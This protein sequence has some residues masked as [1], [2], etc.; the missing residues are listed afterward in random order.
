MFATKTRL[1]GVLSAA[2]LSLGLVACGGDGDGGSGVDSDKQLNELTDAEQI[3]LCESFSAEG[4]SISD[5]TIKIICHLFSAEECTTESVNACIAQFSGQEPEP[6]ECTPEEITCT[7]T[8]GEYENCLDA[9]I[10]QV[11]QIAGEINCA[12]AADYAELDQP[13]ACQAI[14]TK[15]PGFFDDENAEKLIKAS[16]RF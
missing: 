6:A 9:T 1:F 14:E 3:A 13:A 16:R 7:A 11:K 12:N 2:V 8:V 5:E 4:E 10:A 15:C